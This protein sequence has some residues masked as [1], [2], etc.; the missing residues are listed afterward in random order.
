MATRRSKTPRIRDSEERKAII[1]E[2]R[3][4]SWYRS[5]LGEVKRDLDPREFGPI[6]QGG[7]GLLWVDLDALEDRP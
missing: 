4:R 6:L 3:P 7:D 5:A 1:D 2:S